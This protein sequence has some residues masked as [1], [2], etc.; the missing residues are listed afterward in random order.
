MYP[1]L[2]L[3]T[4]RATTPMGLRA[5]AGRPARLTRRLIV[6]ACRSLL[7]P[8]VAAALAL[9]VILVAPSATNVLAH[10]FLPADE[11]DDLVR[12]A[13]DFYERVMAHDPRDRSCGYLFAN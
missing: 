9:F 5:G 1:S 10:G 6:Y 12:Q 2:G 3:Q 11:V 13:G 7:I 4:I 8:R